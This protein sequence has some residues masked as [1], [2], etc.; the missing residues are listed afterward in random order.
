M[1]IADRRNREGSRESGG[2]MHLAVCPVMPADETIDSRHCRGPP[3]FGLPHTPTPKPSTTSSIGRGRGV[4]ACI[5]DAGSGNWERTLVGRSR[6]VGSSPADVRWGTDDGGDQTLKGAAKYTF[7]DGE[8]EK[9][10][11]ERGDGQDVQKNKAPGQISEGEKKGTQMISER[12]H[13]I[14]KNRDRV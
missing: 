10:R 14:I 9:G 7:M 13:R 6:R 1:L 5:W 11:T 8:E 4:Q 2:G 12:K 3:P